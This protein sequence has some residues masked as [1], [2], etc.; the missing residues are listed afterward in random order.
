VRRGRGIDNWPG[1]VLSDREMCLRLGQAGLDLS[2]TSSTA[3]TRLEHDVKAGG[4]SATNLISTR[5]T[6]RTTRVPNYLASRDIPT[7][8]RA[9]TNGRFVAERVC[10]RVRSGRMRSEWI[11]NMHLTSRRLGVWRW[12]ELYSLNS[13]ENR[14]GVYR[15][16]S[17]HYTSVL[18]RT[19]EPMGSD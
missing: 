16:Q 18:L 4:I 6:P 14:S 17:A 7:A 8:L 15:V 19:S 13:H 2:S 11:G 1:G 3:S 12:P 9:R 5:R 10:F